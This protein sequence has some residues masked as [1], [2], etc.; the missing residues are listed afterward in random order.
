[1]RQL[2]VGRPQLGG[3]RVDRV[4][5]IVL[6][7]SSCV[8]RRSISLSISL[9]RSMSCPISSSLPARRARDTGDRG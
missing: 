9:N 7:R 8:S 3:A 4:L 6:L 5:Q 1:V 2:L